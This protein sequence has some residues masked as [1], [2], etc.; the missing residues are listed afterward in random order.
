MVNPRKW[1]DG[2]LRAIQEEIRERGHPRAAERIRLKNGSQ[3]GRMDG[4]WLV[5]EFSVEDPRPGSRP[6]AGT[7]R[8]RSGRDVKIQVRGWRGSSTIQLMCRRPVRTPIHTAELRYHDDQV[9]RL[10]MHRLQEE[11]PRLLT[12]ILRLFDPELA[13]PHSSRPVRR[14]TD[15]EGMGGDQIRAVETALNAP[16][17]RIWGP[18]ARGRQRPLPGWR[19]SGSGRAS[20]WSLLLLPTG[21]R[22]CSFCVSCRTSSGPPLRSRAGS[23]GYGA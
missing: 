18:P 13:V 17:S 21:P 7:L 8:R 22:T 12:E 5:Y 6:F 16:V 2:M 15:T 14:L 11:E 4:G 19:V 1:L 3:V 23:S 9:L 20:R 10:L